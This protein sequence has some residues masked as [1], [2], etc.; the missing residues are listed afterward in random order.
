MKDDKTKSGMTRQNPIGGN[1]LLKKVDKA[2]MISG[3]VQSLKASGKRS[4]PRL[5]PWE[6]L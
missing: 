6:P 5:M 3:G 4:L 2:R 1:L